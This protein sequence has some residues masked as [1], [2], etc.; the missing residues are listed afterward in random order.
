MLF[1]RE[2]EREKKR[3]RRRQCA[4][5][6]DDGE[7][8]TTTCCALC[9][10][11]LFLFLSKEEGKC[12]R[13][14]RRRRNHMCEHMCR[15]HLSPCSLVSLFSLDWIYR[16]REKKEKNIYMSRWLFFRAVGRRA[17]GVTTTTAAAASFGT[18]SWYYYG[19]YFDAISDDE[20]FHAARRV[21]TASKHLVPVYF[22]YRRHVARVRRKKREREREEEDGGRAL[23][24]ASVE[25]LERESRQELW[26]DVAVRLRDL[27]RDNGGIYVKA[28]SICACNR[29]R[30]RLLEKY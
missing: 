13:R 8:E 15:R 14:R 1:E 9:V 30:R 21:A 18:A 7:K 5:F 20:R 23:T 29:S 28:G 6:L 10:S 3:R 26:T 4:R 17:A 11:P 2:R 22:D 19:G 12:W 25:E 24:P 27:A 16:E